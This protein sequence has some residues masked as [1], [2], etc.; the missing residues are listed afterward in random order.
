MSLL[1]INA[2]MVANGDGRPRRPRQPLPTNLLHPTRTPVPKLPNDIIIKILIQRRDIK[3][4]ENKKFMLN[5]V[6][7]P[8]FKQ[9]FIWNLVAIKGS[10]LYA[11]EELQMY[12]AELSSY[13]EKETIMPFLHNYYSDEDDGLGWEFQENLPNNLPQPPLT[14][15]FRSWHSRLPE[16]K[17]NNGTYA[18]PYLQD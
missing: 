13:E 6:P 5:R 16:E 2:E 18:H 10:L 4:E 3:R 8:E 9:K 1:S 17:L 11:Y 15:K 7:G 12:S 14:S